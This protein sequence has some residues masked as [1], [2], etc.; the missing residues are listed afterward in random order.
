MK[1]NK[2]A[3]FT[4][5]SIQMLG[6]EKALFRA[7]K[8]RTATPKYGILF[9]SSFVGSNF[10]ISSKI[11]GVHIGCNSKNKGKVARLLAAKTALVA[12]VDALAEEENTSIGIKCKAQATFFHKDVRMFV[13]DG[14]SNLGIGAKDDR[15]HR[16]GSKI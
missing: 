4:G 16:N 3:S 12:R 10:I 7:L 13:S 8:T 1:L 6:A 5:A 15:K 2:V 9:H 14:D 11:S